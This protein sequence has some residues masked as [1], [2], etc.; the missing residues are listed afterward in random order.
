MTA[1][2]PPVVK[3]PAEEAE[4]DKKMQTLLFSPAAYNLAETTRC[5]EVAR[6]CRGDFKVLFM[7]YGGEFESLITQAG[8]ELERLEPEITPEK[9]D[10][11]YKVDQGRKLG[12]FFTVDEVRAQVRSEL[13]LFERVKPAAVITGFNMSNSISCRAARVPLVWLTQ[14]T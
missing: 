12:T 9:A 14:S 1:D 3:M 5:I 7:S 6:A 11:I 4:R 10:H 13:A 2:S 8:F